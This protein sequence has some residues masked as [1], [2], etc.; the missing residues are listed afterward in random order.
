MEVAAGADRLPAAPETHADTSLHVRY[1]G[2]KCT[3]SSTEPSMLTG[4][5]LHWFG[6]ADTGM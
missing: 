4:A 2:G 6:K 5:P 3:D 1:V